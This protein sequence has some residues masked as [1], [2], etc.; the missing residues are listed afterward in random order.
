MQLPFHT[1]SLSRRDLVRGSMLGTGAVALAGTGLAG[2]MALAQDAGTRWANTS[3]FIDRYVSGGRVPNIVAAL[4]YGAGQ[5]DIIARGQRLFD[6]GGAVDGDTL[7]RIYSMTKPV[8]AMAAM[9][10]IEDGLFTLDTPLADILPAFANMQVQRQYDGPITADNLVAAE[11]PITIRHLLTHTAGLGYSI[12]QRGPIAQAYNRAGLVPGQVSKLPI[13]QQFFGAT[14]APSLEAFADRLAELPLVSQPGRRW[15]YSVGLDLMG[16]VIEVA[17]GQD[18]AAFLQARIFDP[19]GMD[20]TGFRV[21]RRDADRLT[22]NYFR[23][24]GFPV[25]IDMPNNSVYLD[26]PAFAF[27]GAGLVSSARDYDRFLAMLAGGGMLDGR[28]I[29]E[30]ETVRVATSNLLPDTLASNGRFSANGMTFDYGAGGLVGT[31]ALAGVYGWMG[32]AGT[33]GMVDMNRGLRL[34]LMTQYMP[35]ESLPIQAEFPQTVLRDAV[36]QGR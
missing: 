13:A 31:G 14:A 9:I 18:F 19:L 2:G 25:P 10:C 34:T 28:R 15:L 16:R 30:G 1:P 24:G 3:A 32:A 4:G 33:V 5:P 22:A 17:S 7:Y 23:M 36:A 35:A 8:T 20:D 27:G 6:G 26:A 29:M 21:P 11:R 12:I